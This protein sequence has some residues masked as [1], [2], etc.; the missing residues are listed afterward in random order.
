M[1]SNIASFTYENNNQP[2]ITVTDSK[3]FLQISELKGLTFEGNKQFVLGTDEG[4]ELQAVLVAPED[5]FIVKGPQ[6]DPGRSLASLKIYIGNGYT[7]SYNDFVSSNNE[8]SIYLSELLAN[9]PDFSEE[10]YPGGIELI[11]RPHSTTFTDTIIIILDYVAGVNSGNIRVENLTNYSIKMYIPPTIE[12][13]TEV[14][15]VYSYSEAILETGQTNTTKTLKP[16]CVAE[17][18]VIGQ[19]FFIDTPLDYFNV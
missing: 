15:N 9:Y 7:Y 12:G 11:L 3:I 1:E 2:Y 6:G 5:E 16:Y 4:G 14:R 19:H 10:L 8:R 13:E 18:V 17:I